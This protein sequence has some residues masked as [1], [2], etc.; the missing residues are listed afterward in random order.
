M[1]RPRT[2]QAQVWGALAGNVEAQDITV[3]VCVCAVVH[4]TKQTPWQQTPQQ[5]IP[6]S[7]ESAQEKGKE[8]IT[9]KKSIK[10]VF[11]FMESEWES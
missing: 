6:H 4:G 9:R 3:P 7:A 10:T 8:I 11:D 2:S 1:L 5:H